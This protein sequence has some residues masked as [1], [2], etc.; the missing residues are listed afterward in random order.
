MLTHE[1]NETLSR[2]GPG[3]PMGN[4]FRCFWLPAL[5]SADMPAPDSPPVRLRIL[6]EDLVAFR[7]SNGRVGIINAYCSHRLAPLFFGRNEQGGLRCPYHGWKFDVGGNC[8]ETPNVSVKSAGA[9]NAASLKSYKTHEVA[10]VVWVYMGPQETPPD[11]PA[12]D[13]AGTPEG[14]HYSARWIQRSN[15]SQGM[16][17]E[18]DS[19]HISW[20]HEDF[21]K[22]DSVRNSFGSQ[23]GNDR[24]PKIEHRETPY[25]LTYGARR[26]LQGGWYWRVTQWIAPM[27]S[28][29]PHEPGPF[30][31]C[32]GRAW[33]PIDDNHVTVFTFAH[34][35]DRPWQE[36]ELET[37]RSGAV[38]PPRM[39]KGA[40]A[41]P[42]GYV[43]D[44]YL[45][46]ANKE[47]DYL[48]DREMQRTKN[49]SGI[50]GI[51]DQ[52]RSLAESSKP[53][54]P[55]DPGIIDRSQEHLVGS[56]KVIVI[57]RRQLLKM[58][59]DL[60]SGT[61]P[62][63]VARPELFGV[64]AISKICA[65]PDFETLMLEHGHEAR[66]PGGSHDEKAAL[67]TGPVS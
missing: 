2:T 48:I 52:D 10:G 50:W 12:F 38:F 39:T 67:T 66:I 47:N 49:Y 51:H 55:K 30:V 41:L 60:A 18:I 53:V 45:P 26:E 27:F 25:G 19:S 61:P 9:R 11:F 15:W 46:A 4:L 33:V 44:T 1:E 5:L 7:D 28:L 57:A 42:D 17:G 22:K 6:S 62:E 36:E 64:R 24:A 23:H 34:R 20:L 3:T 31:K 40:Y 43:I 56:D 59:K 65:I 54:D 37:F 21:D 35:I 58:A 8:L 29:I 63:M 14:H 16:E 13:H 32:G